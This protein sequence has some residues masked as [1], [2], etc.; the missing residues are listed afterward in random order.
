MQVNVKVTILVKWS[1]S[2]NNCKSEHNK[3]WQ[4]DSCLT[5]TDIQSPFCM[6]TSYDLQV[7]TVRN[8]KFSLRVDVSEYLRRPKVL[9]KKHSSMELAVIWGYFGCSDLACSDLA[10]SDLACSDLA[11]SDLAHFLYQNSYFFHSIFI[12]WKLIY[13]TPKW[14]KFNQMELLYIVSQHYPC[15]D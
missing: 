4:R 11:C 2:I 5:L 10:C 7:W 3:W 9:P 14:N 6:G 8:W 12:I 15:I 1:G 13:H